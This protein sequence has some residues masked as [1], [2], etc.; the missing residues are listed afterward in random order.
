MAMLFVRIPLVITAIMMTMIPRMTDAIEGIEEICA[1]LG[2]G[3]VPL[4]NAENRSGKYNPRHH[5]IKMNII[6]I[7]LGCENKLTG[8][9][10]KS[11]LSILRELSR[12]L[13]ELQIQLQRNR[14]KIAEDAQQ[15]EVMGQTD[16]KTNS[17]ELSKT[18]HLSCF[19]N[20]YF[21]TVTL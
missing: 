10:F 19:S 18:G 14:A 20:P 17:W 2:L 11:I 16:K 6:I 13:Q 12:Q 7:S 9:V 5:S 8:N 1:S 3:K 21:S 15:M 4:L